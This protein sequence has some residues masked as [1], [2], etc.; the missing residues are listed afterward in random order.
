MSKMKI[1]S[2]KLE[3]LGLSSDDQSA[4]Q[5]TI[6]DIVLE[7]VEAKVAEEKEKIISLADEY[8]QQKIEEGVAAEK[9]A[10]IAEYDSVIQEFES[11][12]V[13]KLD[14]FLDLEISSKISDEML[15][16]I[17]IN[18][19]YA[20][21]IEGIKDLFEG[22]YVA[23]DTDG[24]SVVRAKTEEVENLEEKLSSSLADKIELKESCDALKAKLLISE[25]SMDLTESERARVSSFFEGKK[26]DEVESKVSDFVDMIVEQSADSVIEST[27]S[28]KKVLEESIS[29]EHLEDEI[30]NLIEKDEALEEK[31]VETSIL[32]IA[33]GLV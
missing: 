32:D 5:D 28:E 25:Q 30:I 17:A 10:L 12:L 11:E 27:S 6:A 14:S 15:E 18:E 21:I 13:E 22:K 20:P 23:L 3:T 19:T 9:E 26:L 24:E 8:S 31:L 7:S 1:I 16:S 29:E 4:I 33:S 2:E